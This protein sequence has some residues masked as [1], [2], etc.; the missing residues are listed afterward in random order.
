MAQPQV[1]VFKWDEELDSLRPYLDQHG[2]YYTISAFVY[3]S[4][5]E[6]KNVETNNKTL[7][8]CPKE[9]PLELKSKHPEIFENNIEDYQWKDFPEVKPEERETP[10][11]HISGI[12]YDWHR[13]DIINFISS[14]VGKIIPSNLYTAKFKL[15]SRTSGEVEDSGNIIIDPSV[16]M[17]TRKLFK[18]M[19]HN[20]PV[21]FKSDSKKRETMLRCTWYKTAP[22]TVVTRPK[23]TIFPDK[24]LPVRRP[25]TIKVIDPVRIDVSTIGVL[26]GIT[27]AEKLNHSD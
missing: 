6:K 20:I 2:G 7:V 13:S 17:Y 1:Y 26:S 3:W 19:L 23:K 21:K 10:D 25:I 5:K 4:R 9:T 18:L 16:D 22:T 11:L 8:I 27:F 15:R 12:P 14:R 24:A